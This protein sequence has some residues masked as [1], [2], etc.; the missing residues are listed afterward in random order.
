LDAREKLG[1]EAEQRILEYEVKKFP[2]KK[3]E[4]ISPL[5]VNA[6]YD[7][8]SYI[9][10]NSVSFDKFIEVKCISERDLFYWSRNEIDTAK[11]LGENYY[12]Y[13]LE[14]SFENP[15]FEIKNPYKKLYM[16]EQA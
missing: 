14:S 6:G 11:Q 1:S 9:D 4:Y 8:K 7:I 5:D 12:L 2:S 10:N 3:I 15:P 13:L 16:N